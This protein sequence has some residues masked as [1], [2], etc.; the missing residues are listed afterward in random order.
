[1]H[2]VV[3]TGPL[4]NSLL[5]FSLNISSTSRHSIP[6]VPEEPKKSAILPELLLFQ[7]TACKH[8]DFVASPPMFSTILPLSRHLQ[9]Y[10]DSAWSSTP[11]DLKSKK[12]TTVLI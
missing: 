10:L 12:F 6:P 3:V 7:L 4:P 11:V 9:E 8:R 2:L 1:M 5:G